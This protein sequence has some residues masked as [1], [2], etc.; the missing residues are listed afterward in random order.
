MRR[1]LLHIYGPIS[2]HSYG[3]AITIGILTST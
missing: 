3:V 1:E 2:I